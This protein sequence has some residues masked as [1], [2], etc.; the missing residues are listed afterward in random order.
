MPVEL[1][2]DSQNGCTRVAL[3]DSGHLIGLEVDRLD[4]QPLH[5]ARYIA[6][7]MRVTPN[8]GGA[9]LDLGEG[10]TAFLN[11]KRQPLQAGDPVAVEWIAPPIGD[12]LA[13][14]R[15]LSDVA[16][17]GAPRR[18]QAGPDALARAMA[19]KPVTAQV[20]SDSLRLKL[21]PY[22][23]KAEVQSGK[24]PLFEMIDL[25]SQ[26]ETLTAPRVKFPG[27]YLVIEHTE[28]A[29]IIDVNGSGSPAEINRAA[30][31]E[32]ARQIRLRNLGGI[33]LIDLVG[34]RRNI[35]KAILD[36]FRTA[37]QD[38]SC[39]VNIYGITQLGLI[40]CT[41]ERRG[42][43][44]KRLLLPPEGLGIAK[45]EQDSQ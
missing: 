21:A 5:G 14:V 2:A 17:E 38:D 43:E 30:L 15:R 44:L 42:W 41:R 45:T 35:G 27:G 26:I 18:L 7:V 34:D 31:Q 16:A 25:E 22:G 28:A 6:K 36:Q 40:E 1:W 37:T 23:L 33:I 12:K 32:T 20:S 39:P 19:Y 9:E 29:C 3:V 24:P 13:L 8:F 4:C 10:Q 11:T